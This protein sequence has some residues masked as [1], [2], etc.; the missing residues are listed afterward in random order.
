MGFS[1]LSNEQKFLTLMCP[2]NPQFA[3]LVNRFI[4]QMFELRGRMDSGDSIQDYQRGTLTKRL[5]G[6]QLY[7]SQHWS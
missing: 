1:Q 5:K 7:T 4:K 6:P 2:T 3:K